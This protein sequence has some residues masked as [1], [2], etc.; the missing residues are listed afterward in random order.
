MKPDDSLIATIHIS[1]M[2]ARILLHGST[3]DHEQANEALVALFRPQVVEIH[4]LIVAAAEWRKRHIKVENI[5][6]A[7]GEVAE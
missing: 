5:S 4:R 6:S 1:E 7:V 3:Y 2:G